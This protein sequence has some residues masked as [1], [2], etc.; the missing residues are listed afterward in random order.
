M[1]KG[2]IGMSDAEV[3]VYQGISDS[4]SGCSPFWRWM[5]PSSVAVS[6]GKVVRGWICISNPGGERYDGPDAVCGQRSIGVRQERRQV[7]R[8][9]EG[10]VPAWCP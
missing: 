4:P 5:V 8:L 9:R 1:S 6:K 10:Q 7:V 3:Y 2:S